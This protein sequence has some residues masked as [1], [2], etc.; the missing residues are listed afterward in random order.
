[1]PEDPPDRGRAD[2]GTFPDPGNETVEGNPAPWP[3][4]GVPETRDRA[5]YPDPGNPSEDVDFDDER[6]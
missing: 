2:E 5:E 1:M 3:N 4:P 6:G